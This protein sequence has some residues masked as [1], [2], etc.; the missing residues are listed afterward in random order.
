LEHAR[1]LL[2]P[3]CPR[4]RGAPPGGVVD[5]PAS[6]PRA[7]KRRAWCIYA[8]YAGRHRPAKLL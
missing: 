3:N 5:Y 8:T 4:I 6:P 1:I 7:V 2:A